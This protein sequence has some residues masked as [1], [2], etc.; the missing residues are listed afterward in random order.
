MTPEQIVSVR[1][2]LCKHDEDKADISYDLN[3]S[4]LQQ[5][6]DEA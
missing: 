1:N 3:I 4:I 2:Y 5:D 6:L